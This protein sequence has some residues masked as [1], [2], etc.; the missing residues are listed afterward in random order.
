VRL[1][2]LW[3]A[4]RIQ[5]IGSFQRIDDTPN[6]LPLQ[7]QALQY[8]V[9]DASDEVYP[10]ISGYLADVFLDGQRTLAVKWKRRTY[11]LHRCG[12]D[13]DAAPLGWE[14]PQRLT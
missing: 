3:T 11:L 5:F 2:W 14:R 6:D 10:L 9:P 12:A 1:P 4:K 8:P 13:P 7:V